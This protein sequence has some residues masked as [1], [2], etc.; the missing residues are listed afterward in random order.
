[1]F[2]NFIIFRVY[3]CIAIIILI[4]IC[5]FVT[6][7]LLDQIIYYFIFL[8]S[9]FFVDRIGKNFNKT[10]F[11]V[12]YFFKRQQWFKCIIML[13]FYSYY[14]NNN[15]NKSLGI[16]FHYLS[17]YSIARYYYIKALEFDNSLEVLQNLA[18]V[19]RDLKDDRMMFEICSQIHDID[20]NNDIL[21]ELS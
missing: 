17:Y 14:K 5:Y 3:L 4:P 21:L 8:N 10:S 6:I 11:L 15:V 18:L 13:K 12:N 1:M 9:Y 19:Y 2:S 7:E 20:P 16:C